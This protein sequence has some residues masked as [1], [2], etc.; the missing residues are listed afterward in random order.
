MTSCLVLLPETAAI[1]PSWLPYHEG[2]LSLETVNQ[3]KSFHYYI[4]SMIFIIC[5]SGEQ[6][7]V[8]RNFY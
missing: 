6:I 7:N 4:K 5:K 8:L 1:L 2:F 3:N